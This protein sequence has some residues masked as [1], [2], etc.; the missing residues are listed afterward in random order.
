MINPK[1][2][3]KEK[4]EYLYIFLVWNKQNERLKSTV[5]VITL[6]LNGPNNSVKRQKPS[7]WII[8]ARPNNM[9]CAGKVI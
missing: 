9:L 8:K 7:D 1:G 5:P 3:W 4:T 6:N 2:D